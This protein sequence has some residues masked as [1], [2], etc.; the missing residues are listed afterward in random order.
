MNA[1]AIISRLDGF[2][3][4]LAPIADALAEDDARWKPPDGAWSILEVVNHLADEESEDFRTRLR[5]TLESPDAE[6]P[7]IDPEGWASQRRYNERRLRESVERFVRQREESVRWLRSLK[8]PDW[9]ASREHPRAGRLTAADLLASWTAHD[10]LHLRQ[11]ARRLHE[12]AARDADGARTLY[13]GQ[14]SH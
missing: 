8:D 12:M 3:R 6:W 5:L 1:Q 13:A 11:I 14:W 7:P 9:N 2:A 4:I 10:A